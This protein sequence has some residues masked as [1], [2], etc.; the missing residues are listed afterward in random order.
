MS[1][2]KNYNK[3]PEYYSRL[4]DGTCQCVI[5]EVVYPTRFQAQKCCQD[6]KPYSDFLNGVS[7]FHLAKLKS[8]RPLPRL[9]D[10]E[11]GEGIEYPDRNGHWRR[12][13]PDTWLQKRANYH[14]A[15]SQGYDRH[16]QELR[17]ELYELFKEWLEWDTKISP[18]QRLAYAYHYGGWEAV[19]QAA[20][21]MGYSQAI[22]RR[23]DALNIPEIIRQELHLQALIQDYLDT[24]RD[25]D[26]ADYRQAVDDLI[27][28]G[29]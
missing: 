21:N 24:E 16:Y 23:L 6:K 28:S 11:P 27:T 26:R 13:K 22:E 7:A 9:T 10:K 4:P 12:G 5:C 25:V 8:F 2:Q 29:S 20:V 18:L 1:R 3:P 17:R 19:K 15:M 14:K